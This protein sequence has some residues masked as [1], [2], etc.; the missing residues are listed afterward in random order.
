MQYMAILTSK[1]TMPALGLDVVS[2]T[3][4]NAKLQ[5]L[6]EYSLTAMIAG[7]GYGKTT[8]LVQYLLN[9]KLPVSWYNPGPE[10]DNVYSFST[11]LAGA[12]NS[13][14]PG[15][16][17]W[18]FEKTAVD[19]KFDWKIAFSVL[20]AG[21]E[22]FG[23]DDISGIL[24]IDDWQYVQ[25]DM[26][27]RLFVDR[28][29]TCRPLGIH[30]V[31]LSRE[32]T[33]L[34]EF[35]R[36][37]AK[38]QTLDLIDKDLTFDVGE[39]EELLCKITA[40]PVSKMYAE[41]IFAYT[42]GWII[43]IKLLI[44]R[45]QGKQS[46]FSNSA[47]VKTSD[48]D[49][50]F[51]YL[52]QD[53]FERQTPFLQQFLLQSALVESFTVS[54]CKE[55]CGS[56][57][58]S[59]LLNSALKKGLFIYRIGEGIYRYHT[60]FR[61]FLC[62]E[63]ELRLP[64]LT[65]HYAHI[66]SYYW[67]R[68]N[69][70]RALHYFILGEQWELAEK[71]ICEVARHWV[72]SGLYRLLQGCLERMPTKYRQH[73]EIYLAL[74][75]AMRFSCRYDQAIEWYKLAGKHFEKQ[76][77]FVGGSHSCRGIGETYLDSIQPIYAQSYLKQAYKRLPEE[78]L[79]DKA[80]ILGLM[81]ENMINHGSSRR[82]ER[83]Y[84]LMVGMLPFAAED[85]NNLQ[86]RIFLR[87]GRLLEGIEILE[88]RYKQEK[89][90]YHVPR[91]FRETPLILSLCYSYIGEQER[92]LE[93]AQSGID[94]AEKL[95][96]PF[97]T[98]VGY[99]RQG[100][101]L[102][103]NGQLREQSKQAY[104]MALDLA[105]T[106]GILRGKTE[107]F[108][109]LCLLHAL[110]GDWPSAKKIG[111]EGIQITEKVH[112]QWFTAI[113]YHTLGMG[114]ALCNV[115][116]E[117]ETFLLRALHLFE[118]CRDIFGQTACYWWLAFRAGKLKDREAF[119]QFYGRL[120]HNCQ[121][122]GYGFIMERPSLLG[123][124]ADFPSNM[125]RQWAREMKLTN[126]SSTN[127]TS[128]LLVIQTLGFLKVWRD[129]R[130]VLAQEWRRGSS[131]QL[132]NL[133]LTLKTSLVHKETLMYYL[134]PDVD[135]EAAARNFKVVFNNLLNVLEPGR[136]PR[137]PSRYISRHGANYQLV[138]PQGCQL[139]KEQFEQL[140][141]EGRRLIDSQPQQAIRTLLQ[142]MNFYRGEYL[143][144]ENLDELSRKERERLLG[145]AVQGGEMLASLF[146]M[147]ERYDD[148]LIWI[149]KILQIDTCWEKAYQ[150]RMEVYGKL[151]NTV[152]VAR[153]YN[154]CVTVL[155]NEL[156]VSPSSATIAMHKHYTHSSS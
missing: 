34:P 86:V 36:M 42:E 54:Y 73:P 88:R 35:E 101:A 117:A 3:G 31:I 87:T 153:T 46:G 52:A 106:L 137:S 68:E 126:E 141:A 45:A 95:R 83:Y 11:Y 30:V 55:V 4:L 113:L 123:N 51:K 69:A 2:R 26:E 77:D 29:L 148:A 43:A 28:F 155:E 79:E 142:A 147:E 136:L 24:V 110:N 140:I 65:S 44:N 103:L 49:G 57:F 112:D 90:T 121:K 92:A 128:P 115:N 124:I 56:E 64:D 139:D 58:S 8:A 127:S 40:L 21:I 130:E 61:E 18:Y 5:R 41:K 74:G 39:I 93:V 104:L 100:H 109:G 81:A 111:M 91:S 75:D 78:K 132:L 102:L 145:L 108:E 10:D 138:L 7:A 38:G 84:R 71:I 60:L 96:S 32:Q 120:L 146:I 23:E 59:H 98:V 97:V 80:V 14:L 143:Q 66:G 134:W 33:S 150:L 156:G 9:Q 53:V 70:E 99:I 17:E 105:E 62:R 85:K 47:D 154:R 50:L 12:L 116:S 118:Q 13:L 20:M 94:A 37:R 19:E 119:I 63:A 67:K 1:I 122:Y 15:L 89:S 131:R 125:F 114:A 149:Q 129:G 151:G 152:M 27:I 82:A 6:P 22:F 48:L 135:S 107:V 144:G 133:L 72:S 76:H 16:K 25:A